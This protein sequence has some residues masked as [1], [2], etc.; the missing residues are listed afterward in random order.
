MSKV[1]LIENYDYFRECYD[2][3]K[4]GRIHYRICIGIYDLKKGT[5][6]NE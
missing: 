6:K 4:I 2:S 1:G 3:G 5:N